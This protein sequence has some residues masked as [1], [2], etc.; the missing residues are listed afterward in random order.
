MFP[1]LL[2]AS[3]ALQAGQPGSPAGER[4]RD[5]ITQVRRA[6][7]GNTVPQLR[8]QWEDSLRRRPDN[9]RAVFWLAH[10]ASYSF[11]FST[12]RRLFE[13]LAQAPDTLDHWSIHAALALGW[14][15]L[16]RESFDSTRRLATRVAALAKT[17]GDPE[18]RVQA[19]TML[20]FLASRD[21]GIA[22][23]LDFMSQAERDIPRG[24]LELQSLLSCVRAPILS[25]GGAEQAVADL[26]RGMAAARRSSDLWMVGQCYQ[27]AVSVLINTS[28]DARVIEA[29]ADSAETE[30]RASRDLFGLANT[31][32]I[33]GYARLA[34]SDIAGA[35]RVLLEGSA[36][37]DTARSL[38]ASAWI[39]RFT[40]EIHWQANDLVTADREYNAAAAEFEKLG[41]VFGIS[42]LYRRRGGLAL[43]LGRLDEAETIFTVGLRSSESAGIVDGVYSN[44]IALAAVKMAR[45]DWT[46]AR[47]TL[48]SAESYGRAHGFAGWSQG[49]SYYFG[50]SALR[51][52][53]LDRAE[54]YLNDAIRESG[55][56]QFLDRYAARSRLAEL[57]VRRG[58]VAGALRELNGATDQ[59]DSLRGTLDDRSL[60]LLVFQTRREYD[61]SDLGFATIAAALVKQGYVA[62]VFRLAE[63]R[64]AQLLADR[65]LRAQVF[66]GAAGNAPAAARPGSPGAIPDSAGFTPTGT[67]LLEYLTGTGGQPTTL[68]ITT[69]RGQLGLV[70]APID[71]LQ[72][73]LVRFTTA[74]EAGSYPVALGNRL[75]EALLD[76]ALALLPDSI[77]RLVIVPDGVLYQLPFDALP[78]A[79]GVPLIARFAVSQAPSAAIAMALSR[80]PVSTRAPRVLA[81][82]DPTFAPASQGNVYRSAYEE[83]GGLPRLPLSAAEARMAAGFGRESVLRLG[84]LANESFVKQTD[85][86]PF[87]IIH[88]AT[89]AMVDERSVA[90]T[91]LAL[92]A[93]DGDDGFLS[94]GEVTALHLDAD[95]VVLSGCRTAGG[96]LIGGEGIQGLASALL[97]AGARSVVATRWAVGDRETARLIEDFYREL[98]RGEPVD[99]ALRLAKLA[100]R[101]RGVSPGHWA[102]FSV[103]GDPEVRIPLKAPRWF[104][105]WWLGVV[106]AAGYLV[107][108][109]ARRRATAS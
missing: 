1:I 17:A 16:G 103:I 51:L 95:L 40:G 42:G 62:D 19:L 26:R 28:G 88:F 7:R 66:E 18:A 13:R 98:A 12:G 56:A 100:A 44:W 36:I 53:E 107:W 58:D 72:D 45:N 21:R 93:G 8:A 70:L 57:L 6:V 101:D 105:L 71:S 77:R 14:L 64:R 15:S 48:Q 25:F 31:L 92:T 37:A 75:R 86:T 5:I 78:Q 3:I 60:R 23:A 108:R 85:L 29:Y 34:R 49:L 80:R 24:D 54:R 27:S 46:G 89:H 79:D 69:P 73:E 41:D 63:R 83:T 10:I 47:N 43:D 4:P 68:L 30:E 90:R 87:R 33:R 91:S 82:G 84:A 96:V 81:F 20:G 67:A 2:A 59:L 39:H 97:E 76:R 35:R 55:P 102:A 65:L 22:P 94:P 104:S 99:E 32:F 9:R 52:G 61:E 50:L 74:L 106:P 38:F 109:L 11:D